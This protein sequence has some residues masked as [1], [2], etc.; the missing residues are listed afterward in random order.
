MQGDR[1]SPYRPPETPTRR[2]ASDEWRPPYQP[3][4]VLVTWLVFLLGMTA[5]VDAIAVV[6]DVA[7]MQ[8]LDDAQRG[9]PISDERANAND[10]RQMA[11]GILAFLLLIPTIV[12]FCIWIYRANLNARALGALN[13]RF[14]PGWCVG[15]FFI[16]IMNLFRP[17]QATREIWLA[18]EP[19]F[20]SAN[21]ERWKRGASSP[22]LPLWWTLWIGSGF[23]GQLSFRL[24]LRADDLPALL[25]SSRITLI[26]DFVDLCLAIVALMLVRAIQRRQETRREAVGQ[27]A[28]AGWEFKTR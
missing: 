9:R 7:E 24:S 13:M 10:L 17:Y 1:E 16:P 22:I 12:L 26:S 5:V 21:R 15:W 28:Q 27:T 18:S 8:L 11:I 4:K 6:S 23:L 2:S 20:D 14:T 25:A 3:A 19:T